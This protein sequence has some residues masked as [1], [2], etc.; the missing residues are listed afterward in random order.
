MLLESESELDAS[1]L[2]A[3]LNAII[4]HHDALRIRLSRDG[5]VWQQHMVA[6]A[7][8]SLLREIGAR[9]AGFRRSAVPRGGGPPHGGTR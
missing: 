8:E 4:E 6:P 5:G 7:T 3:A 2:N 1:A 9:P